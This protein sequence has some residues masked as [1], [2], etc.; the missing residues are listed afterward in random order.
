MGVSDLNSDISKV[1]DG[2]CL[3]VW[4]QRH[5]FVLASLAIDVA[6]RD[7]TN[8]AHDFS[9]FRQKVVIVVHVNFDANLL[10]SAKLV[11]GVVIKQPT[12]FGT[13]LL[14]L[15]RQVDLLRAL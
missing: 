6:A 1:N 13:V 12:Y 7:E 10:Q 5:R 4:L 2:A 9:V 11:A 3:R 14:A 15:I 8:A